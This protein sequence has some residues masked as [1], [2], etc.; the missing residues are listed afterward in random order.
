V[1]ISPL[2]NAVQET[3]VE[4]ILFVIKFSSV[5]T[6]TGHRLDGRGSIPGRNKIFLFCTASRPALGSTQ[7]PMQWVQEGLSLG[8]KWARHEA[9]HSPPANA[10]VKN[11]GT[12][13]LLLFTAG[14]EDL[15]AHWIGGWVGTRAGLNAVEKRTIFLLQ[16]IEPQPSSP[17]PV[18]IPTEL[19]RRFLK[20]G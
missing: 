10:E 7:P 8:V 13:S 2:P 3:N 5:A 11:G 14:D 17:Q 6:A 1:Y 4:F 16:G 12:V 20:F 15:G 9:D 19:S 18:A